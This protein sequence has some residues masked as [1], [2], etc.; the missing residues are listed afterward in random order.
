MQ[1]NRLGVPES[2]SN[3]G[4]STLRVY[5]WE[6]RRVEFETLWN[7]ELYQSMSIVR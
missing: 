2:M 6:K 1:V 7:I 4:L 3:L 5:R